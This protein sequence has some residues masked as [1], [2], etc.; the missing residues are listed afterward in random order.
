[1]KPFSSSEPGPDPTIIMSLAVPMA[2]GAAKAEGSF[3]A[4]VTAGGGVF[5]GVSAAVV[6][7]TALPVPLVVGCAS[8][9]PFGPVLHVMAG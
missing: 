1:M 4:T 2:W 3:K 9:N 6:G 8:I 5:A 7:G